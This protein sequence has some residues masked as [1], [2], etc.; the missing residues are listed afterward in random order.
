[1]PNVSKLIYGCCNSFKNVATVDNVSVK[2]ILSFKMNKK[3][4]NASEQLYIY[5]SIYHILIILVN[6]D[7]INVQFVQVIGGSRKY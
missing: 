4:K 2:K 6:V 7:S 3:M 5:I 1:M